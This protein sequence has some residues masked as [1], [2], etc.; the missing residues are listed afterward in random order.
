MY[1][2]S[3]GAAGF[4]TRP[5]PRAIPQSGRE[6][7]PHSGSHYSP[8]TPSPASNPRRRSPQA[9][10]PNEA[11]LDANPHKPQ[12]LMPH[13]TNPTNPSPPSPLPTPPFAFQTLFAPVRPAAASIK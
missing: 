1:F 5:P 10:I 2:P 6:R 3:L 9:K 12:P 8:P 13:E 4:R 7:M 11:T